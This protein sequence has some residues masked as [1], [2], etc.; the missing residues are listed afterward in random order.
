MAGGDI[1]RGSERPD[2]LPAAL[3]LK[4]FIALFLGT[5]ASCTHPLD[6]ILSPMQKKAHARMSVRNVNAMIRML[7]H[8]TP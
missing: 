7:P 8:R 4:V 5:G 1:A 2:A 6:A 3:F